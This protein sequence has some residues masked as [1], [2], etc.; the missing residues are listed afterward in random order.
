MAEQN[1]D[2]LPRI[3]PPLLGLP[4]GEARRVARKRAGAKLTVKL[5]DSEEKQLH[6]VRQFPEPGDDLDDGR[7][8]KVEIA[9]RPWIQFL[10]GIYQDADEENADFL[11]RFLLISAHLISGIEERLEYL[12]EFFD[13][14]LTPGAFLPWLASWLAM[15][16]LE[17]WTRRSAARSSS[18][19]PSCTGCAA[20][21]G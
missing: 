20:P 2:T 5:V 13:P 10:P 15:P 12:H 17:G 21:P 18:A 19:C 7:S 6:V 1:V 4:I 11:Q 9:T 14:R 16:L 8:M 3:A